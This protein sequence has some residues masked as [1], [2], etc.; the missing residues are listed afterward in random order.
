MPRYGA[1]R[2]RPHPAHCTGAEIGA[3]DLYA[4]LRLRA[5]VFVVEQ[6][7]VYLDP[8]GR[9]LDAGTTHL[10]LAAGDGALAA[11]LR[12]LT[13]PDRRAP[14]RPGGHRPRPPRP[15]A[16]RPA[17]RSRPHH[18][19]SGRWCSTPSRTS[20]HVYARHGFVPDGPE[21]LEDGIPHT[22]MRLRE[23]RP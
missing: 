17:A 10:W 22:P 13:E 4:A 9:D 16:R 8:D 1:D 23:P 11:Y 19:P 3:A 5:E 7:C 6:A 15:A 20:S 2:G 12:V 21:F 14:H 18:S